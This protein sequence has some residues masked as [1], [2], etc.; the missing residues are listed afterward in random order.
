MRNTRKNKKGGD[1]TPP[2]RSRSAPVR[3]GKDVFVEKSK[4][5]PRAARRAV[6]KKASNAA[7]IKV[8]NY[9]PT[10]TIQKHNFLEPTNQKE[11][12]AYYKKLARSDLLGNRLDAQRADNYHK[13]WNVW[14]AKNWN[15]SWD[16][17]RGP[18]PNSFL[19]KM[20]KKTQQKRRAAAATQD[21]PSAPT[22]LLA[23]IPEDSVPSVTGGTKRRKNGKK[24]RTRKTRR[25][26]KYR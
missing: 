17:R 9:K 4:A 2:P 8:S 1:G 24:R 16:T 22:Q 15:W 10:K 12:E 7:T 19:S 23:D 18:K 3:F 13:K 6:P 20:R 14:P 21:K 5:A 25:T 11:L 26:R